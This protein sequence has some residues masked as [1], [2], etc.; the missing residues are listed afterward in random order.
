MKTLQRIFILKYIFILII[1]YRHQI[2]VLNEFEKEA[3]FIS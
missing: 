1:M 3:V 2:L